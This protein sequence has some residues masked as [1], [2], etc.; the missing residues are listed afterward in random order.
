MLQ[1]IRVTIL[2]WFCVHIVA[3]E[4]C[5]ICSYMPTKHHYLQQYWNTQQYIRTTES[6]DRILR[7]TTSHFLQMSST[8]YAFVTHLTERGCISVHSTTKLNNKRCICS[9]GREWGEGGVTKETRRVPRR[10]NPRPAVTLATETLTH[11]AKLVSLQSPQVRIYG[12]V[13]SGR[14]GAGQARTGRLSWP[15]QRYHTC[16][17]CHDQKTVS[18]LGISGRPIPT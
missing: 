1:V 12:F 14:L 8:G 13:T 17:S 7:A 2:Y 6:T 3:N 16:F 10:W 18:K 15:Q 9:I 5:I 4:T 11:R